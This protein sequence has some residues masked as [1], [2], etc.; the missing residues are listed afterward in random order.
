MSLIAT[1]DLQRCH[2]NF[3]VLNLGAGVQSTAMALLFADGKLTPMPDIAIFADTQDEED[4]TYSHLEWLKEQCPFPIWVRTT[5]KLSANLV[6]GINSTGQRFVSIPAF[7][8]DPGDK[9]K[10]QIRRQCTAEYKLKPITLAVR[11]ELIGLKFR[12]RIP[13]G[14]RI[15][16]HIGISIDEAGRMNRIKGRMKKY[17]EGVFDLIQLEWT[18]SDCKRYLAGRCPHPVGRSACKFCPYKSDDEWNEQKVN[19]PESFEESCRV[20]EA[21]RVPGNVCNRGS[22]KPMF[23]HAS[24]IPLRDVVFKTGVKYEQ[25]RFKYECTGLCGN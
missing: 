22:D 19:R 17:E 12:Q 23:L 9:D 25:N 10:G 5:G 14:T 4:Y 2:R 1:A 11:R 21:L 18:R 15:F 13:K 24:C 16:H 20:D 6:N 7:T 3:H 8:K